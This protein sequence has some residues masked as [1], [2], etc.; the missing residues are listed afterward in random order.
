MDIACLPKR[1][2]MERRDEIYALANRLRARAESCLLKD[3]PQLQN[4]LRT[5]ARLL[6]D[7]SKKAV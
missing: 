5:A 3:Q 2:V 4:D 6:D 1:P 7:L